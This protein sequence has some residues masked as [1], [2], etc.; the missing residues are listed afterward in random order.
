L[1]AY[2]G[3]LIA[4]ASPSAWMD[5]MLKRAA[6][7]LRG[8]PAQLGSLRGSIGWQSPI[9]FMGEVWK[10]LSSLP[11]ATAGVALGLATS[12]RI[13]GPLAGLIGLVYLFGVSRRNRLAAAAAYGVWAAAATYLSWPF[14]WTAPVQRLLQSAS[15][16]ANFPWAGLV[17]FDGARYSADNLPWSY[18]PLLMNLQLTETFLLICYSA[19]GLSLWQL[20]FARVRADWLSYVGLGF[21][22]PL[23]AMILFRPP[24]YDNF[25]QL[26]F[27]LPAAFVLAASGVEALF[28]RIRST[29]IRLALVI[30]VSLPGISAIVRLH[31]YQYVYYNSLA[32]GVGG[33][34]DRF[35]LDYWRTSFREIA[36]WLNQDAAPGAAIITVGAS[37]TFVPYARPD[38]RVDAGGEYDYAIIPSKW[39]RAYPDAEVLLTIER[40]GAVLATVRRIRSTGSE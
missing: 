5:R 18:L 22:L 15:I 23:A 11:V 9:A 33:A 25:R 38:L 28:E 27:L 1:G 24:L 17:L 16:M 37:H 29:W 20:L 26:L 6:D 10:Q 19:V 7:Y 34:A 40:D 13:L 4:H 8:I 21:G 32:G 39:G 12:V 31:P 3:L 14:L 30:A 35:E 36:L 2:F